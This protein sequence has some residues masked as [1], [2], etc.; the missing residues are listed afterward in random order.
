MKILPVHLC[1]V[2]GSSHQVPKDN[3][4]KY[5]K[6]TS[7]VFM[8]RKESMMQVN[9]CASEFKYW[10]NNDANSLLNN[11]LL[12][13][14]A[15]A[16]TP[17]QSVKKSKVPP[18]TSEEVSKLYSD[19]RASGV[20]CAVLSLVKDH[21][22]HFIPEG[23]SVQVPKPLSELYCEDAAELSDEDVASRCEEIFE[24]LSITSAQ[25]NI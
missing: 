19:L 8:L 24:S 5:V 6:W 11:L 3:T 9:S 22:Q 13:L 15:V 7:P 16:E 21:A 2:N 20:A 17:T 25:V 1:P 10:C 12:F 4:K 18:M 23:A 14:A